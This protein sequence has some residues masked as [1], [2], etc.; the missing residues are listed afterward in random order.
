[1]QTHIH[2]T[3]SSLLKEEKHMSKKFFQTSMVA[4]VALGIFA[5]S[6][7]AGSLPSSKSGAAM[8]NGVLLSASS[9]GITEW[10]EVLATYIKVAGGKELAMDL[11]VQ[12]GLYTRT[13]ASSKGGKK[14]TS[15]A[16]GAVKMRVKIEE[17]NNDGSLGAPVYAHPSE[18]GG[19]TYCS[20]AQTLSATFQGIF[21]TEEEVTIFEVTTDAGVEDVL[22]EWYS[23]PDECQNAGDAGDTLE[24]GSIVAL[25][26]CTSDDFVG[27][28]LQKHPDTDA[29]LLDL[30]CLEP[31]EVEL[32]LDTLNAN[33]FNYVSPNLTAG[34]YKVTAESMITISGSEQEGEWEANAVVGMGSMIV[35]EIRF[36]T[37]ADGAT[38]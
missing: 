34:I 1:L 16:E 3:K 24:D 13:L 12:C 30:D 35:D 2:K 4:L 6:A 11:A 15:V 18:D 33:A 17:V 5:T 26:V 22:G 19:V 21:Q 27:T 20:R 29:I 23:T 31:E 37:N 28:C 25:N 14:D 38:E 10:D 9:A 8:T 7:V 32:I 36:I